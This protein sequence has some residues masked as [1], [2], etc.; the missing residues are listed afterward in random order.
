[1]N[2]RLQ[3]YFHPLVNGKTLQFFI[4]AARNFPAIRYYLVYALIGP[5]LV[6]VEQSEFPDPRFQG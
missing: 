6:V 3:S 4:T 5:F 1:M 2:S